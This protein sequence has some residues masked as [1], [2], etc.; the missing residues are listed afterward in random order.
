[1]EGTTAVR[2]RD[3]AGVVLVALAVGHILLGGYMLIDPGS[4]FRE[5][6]PFGVRNDHYTRD[7]GTFTL[8]LGVGFAVAARWSAWRVGIVGYALVQYVLHTINHLVDIDKAHP[9]RAGPLDFASL[10]VT[11]V[12]LGWLLLR[13]LRDHR[14]AT[15]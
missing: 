6:G 15:W 9:H 10:A 4:F 8:A 7:A 11:A 5:I 14:A 13:V 1:V 3:V 12:V 2:G